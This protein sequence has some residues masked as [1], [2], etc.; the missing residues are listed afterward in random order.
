MGSLEIY[1]KLSQL[2]ESL[3]I[4]F[5]NLPKRSEDDNPGEDSEWQWGALRSAN[6]QDL[7]TAPKWNN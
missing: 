7:D 3:K 6:N 1:A 5:R 4:E 2:R